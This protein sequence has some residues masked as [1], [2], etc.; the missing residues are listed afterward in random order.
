LEIKIN[1]KF[2]GVWYYD[3]MNR[4]NFLT[5]LAAL[6]FVGVL[7]SATSDVGNVKDN[8][9]TI[10]DVNGPR[11][12]WT[13]M[14]PI[15]IVEAGFIY[16]NVPVFLIKNTSYAVKT[17]KLNLWLEAERVEAFRNKT[18]DF[19][20]KQLAAAQISILGLTHV[21]SVEF[22]PYPLYNVMTNKPSGHLAFVRGSKVKI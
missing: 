12:P 14:S 10:Y 17:T 13:I 19:Y 11:S 21:Y 15:E 9:N 20:Y 22:S 18:E 8:T 16:V 2:F 6:P 4:R 5:S 3:S 1:C 7:S